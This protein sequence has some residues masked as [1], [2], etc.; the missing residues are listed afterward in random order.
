MSNTA[1]FPWKSSGKPG[2]DSSARQAPRCRAPGTA[3]KT[4]IPAFFK[5]KNKET[6]SAGRGRRGKRLFV[7][8]G[9]ARRLSG[10]LQEGLIE[11]AARRYPESDGRREGFFVHLGSIAHPCKAAKASVGASSVGAF[12]FFH[13]KTFLPQTPAE[14]PPLPADRGDLLFSGRKRAPGTASHHLE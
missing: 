2:A 8:F 4:L 13:P 7:L 11:A 14:N 10:P 3:R 1:S 12:S 9:L 6:F 5:G